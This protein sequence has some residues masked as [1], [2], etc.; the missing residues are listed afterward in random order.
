MPMP[1]NVLRSDWPFC[2]AL[3]CGGGNITAS[4][5]ATEGQRLTVQVTATDADGDSLAI[6]ANLSGLPTGATFE[7]GTATIPG[8]LSWTPG[9]NDGRSTPYSVTFTASNAMLIT[10]TS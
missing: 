4:A 2:W 9:P 1:G 10:G 6:A 8:I 7:P 3:L 5:S